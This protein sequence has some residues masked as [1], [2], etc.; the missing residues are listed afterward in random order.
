MCHKFI[1]LPNI[2]NPPPLTPIG[3]SIKSNEVMSDSSAT[4]TPLGVNL[5]GLFNS[6]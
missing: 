2:V 3:I 4:V 6:I 1:I 5:V